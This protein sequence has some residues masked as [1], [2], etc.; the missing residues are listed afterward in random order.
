M[1]FAAIGSAIWGWM[2]TLPA[3]VWWLFLIIA[4]GFA[5]DMRARG[6]QRAKDKADFDKEAAAVESE[7]ISNIQENTDEVIH[8]A[9]AVREHT[10]AG[11]LS[12]GGATLS[13]A[14]Y[15]D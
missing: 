6:Q 5:I 11:V 10:S 2:K 14:N 15:R 7:V 3:W 13:E 8:Q 1:T 9:D 4:A 12:N